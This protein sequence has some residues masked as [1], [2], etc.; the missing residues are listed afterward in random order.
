MAETEANAVEPPHDSEP[1]AG[2]QRKS[3]EDSRTDEWSANSTQGLFETE[4]RTCTI[5]GREFNASIV[6]VAG[7]R[8]VPEECP[9]CGRNRLDAEHR[10][11]M[12]AQEVQHEDQLMESMHR[13]GVN[14]WRHG[15]MTLS[16]LDP[17]VKVP[18]RKW[19][20]RVITLRKYQ[21]IESLFITGPTGTGKTQ[22]LACVIREFLERGWGTR[23]MIFDRSR[24]M[25]TQLQDRYSTGNVDQFSAARRNVP[26]WL[27]DDAGT[28]KLTPDA[29]RVLE[30]IIDGREGRPTIVTSNL[31]RKEF[32]KRWQEMEGWDRLASRLKYFT[33]IG[34]D[35]GDRRSG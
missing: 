11:Q 33:A 6:K 15:H 5:C 20:D 34:L 16:E 30:D 9:P 24:A 22:T 3:S 29:L 27:L 31:S 17:M 35:G 14:I 1:T 12:Q 21:P 18:V 2:T 10:E 28:E 4:E 32:A 7:Q 26:V 23:S 13:V 19:I 8:I 25:I